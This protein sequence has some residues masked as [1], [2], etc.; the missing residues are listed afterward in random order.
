MLPIL[1]LLAIAPQSAIPTL[2]PEPQGR[3][4]ATPGAPSATTPTL[5]RAPPHCDNPVLRARDPVA[6][7]GRLG[8]ARGGDVGH[9]LLLERSIDGCPAPLPVNRRVPGSNAVGRVFGDPR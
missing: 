7:M 4:F 6:A 8:V 3:S 5:G 2:P 9:Y 1:M